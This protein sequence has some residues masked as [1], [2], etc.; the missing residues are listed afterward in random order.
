MTLHKRRS[1]VGGSTY[2][3]VDFSRIDHIFRLLK[4]V[5]QFT[6]AK[7]STYEKAKNSTYENDMLILYLIIE[8][9]VMNTA[10]PNIRLPS[11]IKKQE[12]TQMEWRGIRATQN[13]TTQSGQKRRPFY[14]C[15]SILFITTG[16]QL[17]QNDSL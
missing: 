9:W 6:V 4:S 1:A 2:A 11:R 5:Q 13:T 10:R 16:W 12:R 15:D 7:D 17:T 3:E 14:W 8:F